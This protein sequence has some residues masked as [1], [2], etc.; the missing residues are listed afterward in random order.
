MYSIQAGAE[1]MDSPYPSEAPWESEETH[2]AMQTVSVYN[3]T[4]LKEI[5]A[6]QQDALPAYSDR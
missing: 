1:Y 5:V 3:Q 4:F 2:I 6:H